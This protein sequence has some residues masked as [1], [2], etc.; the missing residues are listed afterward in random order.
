MKPN[1]FMPPLILFL[2]LLLCPARLAAETSIPG[3]Y[4]SSLI[5]MREGLAH[6]FVEDLFRDSK[7]FIW[8]AT[9]GSLSRYDGYEFLNFNPNT[10]G[11]NLKSTFV[12]KVCE[13]CFG[14]LWVASDGGIDLIDLENL[15]SI[16]PEDHSGEF[17][18]LASIP[19]G[20]VAA[21]PD[22]TLWLRNAKDIIHIRFNKNGA[23][24]RIS[25][26]P[27]GSK[28][29]FT[30]SAIKPVSVNGK[31]TEVWSPVNGSICK[32]AH[33]DGILR[34]ILVS[35]M[36]K[37]DSDVHV[38]D[39]LSTDTDVWIATEVGLYR[40]NI[41]SGEV[42]AYHSDNSEGSISQNFIT[43]L[44]LGPGGNLVAASLNGLNIYDKDRDCFSRLKLSDISREHLSLN[45]N[46]INCL[47]K[48][49]DNLWAG[50]EGCGVSI[51][52]PK[53]IFAN[54]FRHAPDNPSSI[55]PNPVNA[56]YEDSDG[57]LWVGTVE[58][59]LNYAASGLG[60][61]FL[62]V[63]APATLSHN[64][65][66]AITA[67]RRGQLWVGTWG[68]GINILERGNPSKPATV[69]RT[70]P[71]GKHKT[72]YIGALVYDPF[73]NAVWVG[74]NR[75]IFVYFLDSGEMK[76]P[77][78]G[79][80]EALGSVA[81]TITA[82]GKLW[83]GGLDGLYAI[84]LHKN[85]AREFNVTR[86]PYKL[87]HP[88]TKVS[89][90]VTAITVAH[91]G[92]IWVGTNGNGLYRRTIKDG[93]ESFINY[94]TSDGLPNDVV[95]GIAEDTGGN[96]WVATYH[97]LA[98]LQ[99]NGDIVTYDCR[100]GL[101]TEQFYWNASLRMA[102]GEILFGSIDGLLSVKGI[103]PLSKNPFGV[104]FTSL[105]TGSGKTYGHPAGTCAIPE[106][107]KSF[108]IGFS[109]LDFAGNGQGRFIYRMRG[110]DNEWKELPPGRNSVTY[111]NLSPGQYSLEV[112]YARPGQSIHSSPLA[113]FEI[114]IVPNFYKRW[115]FI[116]LMVCLVS[117]AVWAIY[118]WRVKDLT[119]QRNQLRQAVD[120]G[121]KEIR[122]QKNLIETHAQELS[123]QNE[124]LKQRNRQI[125]EQKTQLAEMNRKVQKMTVDRISFFTNITHEF[126]TPIT[127]II[128]PIERALK[129]STNPKVIEQ[130]NFVERNSKYLLSLVNQ[131]MDF[132]KVEAGKIE[133]LPTRSDFVKFINELIPPFRAY[134]EERGIEIRTL[135]HLSSPE[136]SYD[137]EAIRKVLTNLLG[138]AIKFTPD[139]G[140]VT[141][142][143]ALFK[144]ARCNRPNTLYLGVSDTGNG[145][146]DD[147]I[148]KVFDRF[149]QGKSQIK[150]PLIG[151]SDS[152]IGLYLC[153]KIMEVYGGSI[154]VKNNHGAGC[155]F[156]VLVGV[157]DE[158]LSQ[159]APAKL[160]S[161]HS[162]GPGEA[163][164]RADGE[165][166]TIL[167]VEDN[168]DMRAFMRSIL[169][170]YYYV[171]EAADGKEAMQVLLSSNIDFI[172]SDLM[173]PRMD[174]IELS[175][176]VK[177]NFAISH[178]PFLMLTAKT[179]NEA[180]LESFRCGVDEYL[181]KPFDE[182]I[183]LARIKNIL[184]NKRRYQRQF[185]SKMQSEALNIPDDSSDK[186]F[187]DK[188]LEVAEKNY[189]NSYFEVGDFAEALGVS[190][191]L[192]NKKLQSLTGESPNQFIRS[193]RLK[194]AREM[195]IK[196]RET[197]A[198]NISE[199]AFKVGF[200]DSK[201]FT[202]CF[203][204]QFGV[205][206]S[207]F[208]KE[209]AGNADNE[210]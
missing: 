39:F 148:D 80:S 7:G 158:D 127:L 187:V 206:P 99:S 105:A 205:S 107:E 30:T 94:N 194:I 151:A 54:T 87:D 73:N 62:H 196:N 149:Y 53:T 69:L 202:R 22:S 114:E 25:R 86:H 20:Y 156:R 191:S 57:T 36:L 35:P 144:S 32:I 164:L 109:S 119:R 106:N 48:E 199:I 120:N 76:T 115:W 207:S 111:T 49:G 145:L 195:L 52:H 37:L 24:S 137:R 98:C 45:S 131:L 181:Q 84:D 5:T 75:G 8:I 31:Q 165:K 96:I 72:D 176:Q 184:D 112:K 21:S 166:L 77:F 6:N 42:K 74:A 10:P 51:I 169:S 91:D 168:T 40:Y 154:S 153:R 141:L 70:T 55:S 121:V 38:S 110:F 65:V 174:G 63:K 83:M 56:I 175:R 173:M 101:D 61:G 103:A 180:R 43:A 113:S 188:V 139:H 186:K 27:H 146:T 142:H 198:M 209:D 159:E 150:Y 210:T 134:A 108:E 90:K 203:T 192:L 201:Y 208:L 133:I 130:L 12:R 182:E 89:E 135:F 162:H 167:V 155:T 81:A 1:V 124:E 177:E 19:S 9:S 183:L 41:P 17:A 204:K 163:E 4:S 116:L 95:H 200:N 160:P 33:N 117:G 11:R 26:L 47:L 15:H 34:P 59:G 13:D 172:I 123:Q 60:N 58:G 136:F 85:R 14:R 171:E 170:D 50:T 126:R 185:A 67:D 138:N 66:S 46:F 128:G 193:Y 2:V 18:L 152:G 97:G 64:S 71:D 92:T 100:N 93:K 79:A 147:D 143:A 3:S 44:A 78:D 118:R 178:I 140:R 102:N 88:E 68:G 104:V 122:Q 189:G 190:R 197:R 132:R 29:I 129:L 23:I 179:A 125:S 157:P 28:S 82:D 16:N 161:I